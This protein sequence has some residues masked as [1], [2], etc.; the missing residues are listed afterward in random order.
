VNAP[1]SFRYEERRGAARITLSRPQK[2]NALTFQVYRELTDTF[3]ELK[4]KPELRAVSLTGEGSGFCSGGDVADIIGPLLSMSAPELLAFTRMTCELVAAIRACPQ[5]VVA[6]INGVAA[7][8]GA[9]IALA[10][11]LRLCA[12]SARFQFLFTKVGLAGADM[13]AAYL[14]PRVIGFGRATELLML[15]DAVSAEQAERYGLANRVVADEELPKETEA[16]LERLVAGPR[17]GLAMTKEALNRELNFDLGAALEAEAQAQALCMGHPDFK[18]GFAA[19]SE[20]R[21]LRFQGAP[22]PLPGEK[23]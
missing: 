15:G 19:F 9:A 23:K 21:P 14:L 20:K 3:H 17:F 7:G 10:C 18:E 6:A 5:P 12:K 22:D 16:L 2:K 1:T 8:A 11:D 13:G 4:K